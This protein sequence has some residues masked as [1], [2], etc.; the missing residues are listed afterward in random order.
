LGKS[1]LFLYFGASD[2]PWSDNNKRRKTIEEEKGTK[3]CI[4]IK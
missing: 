3:I 4:P 2:L 1:G